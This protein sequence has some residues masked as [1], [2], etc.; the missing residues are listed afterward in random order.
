[1]LKAQ[2]LM[3]ELHSQLNCLRCSI[4]AIGLLSCAHSISQNITITDLK[5]N[6]LVGV[7]VFSEDYQFTDISNLDGRVTVNEWD[8]SS[9]L[10]FRFLGFELAQLTF[11]SL[12]AKDFL[13]TLKPGAIAIEEVVIF[14]RNRFDVRDIPIQTISFSQKEIRSTQPQSTADALANHG[15]IFVQKSQMGGGSPVIRGFEANRVLLVI[16]GIRM[17][18]AIYRNGHLQN[19][20][21]TDP[22]I[23]D[24]IDVL[25]GAN[26]L[27]FGSDAL[28]GVVHFQTMTPAF[29]SQREFSAATKA[30][31][32]YSTANK[33]KTAHFDVS[34][35]NDKWSSLTS[36]TR[37][38][39]DDLR[40]GAN[41]PERYPLFGLRPTYQGLNTEGEDIMVTNENPNVQVGTA[42]DQWDLLQKLTHKLDE[43]ATLQ[44]N[45]QYSRSSDIPRYDNLTE[46]RNGQLRFA[47]WYYGPQKRWM[48]SASFET[49]KEYKFFD[50][51]DIIASYQKLQESRVSRNFGSVIRSSQV[52]DVRVWEFAADMTKLLKGDQLRLDYGMH[53]QYNDVVSTASDRN[54]RTGEINEDVLTRYAS[55]S[56]S[57]WTSGAFIL[58]T[59]KN[60]ALHWN[61]GLR[62]SL[63]GY[64]LRYRPASIVDW[65]PSFLDGV[66][67]VNDA[68][69]WSAGLT[70]FLPYDM[71]VKAAASTAFRAPNVD[72][73]SRIRINSSE[74]SFPNLNLGP[75]RSINAE[76][77]LSKSFTE[78]FNISATGYI[79]RLTDAIAMSDFTTPEGL[80]VWITQGD[81]LNVVANQNL[82]KALIYGL[83]VNA[84]A[85]FSQVL[86]AT[87][88]INW[89][90]GRQLFDNEDAVP[91]GHIPPMYGTTELIYENDRFQGRLSVR[92]NGFKSID[93]FG[94]SVD[95]PEFATPEGSLAWTT[96]NTYFS[97]KFS[98][99]L[100]LSAAVENVFDIHYRTFSSGVSA[101]GRNVLLTLSG[102]F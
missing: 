87:S 60:Q 48:T 2:K 37:S 45:M 65:P 81:T 78:R 14:G 42:Y 101:P 38:D 54:I 84:T 17:N 49:Y 90:R 29:T 93:A 51:L 21:T 53:L 67:G 10:N 6:P 57:Y 63:S 82:E 9:E 4:L 39:F 79:T 77:T 83:S 86:S 36:V 52:E 20:I 71:I 13:V 23:M 41:R 62:Y 95:N 59:V 94:G 85:E 99:N 75:E 18:N 30:Y 89:T 100:S 3:R 50:E 34:L 97:Y 24:R 28:G 33:E 15:N 55:D 56:N 68:L 66:S 91:L 69:T 32:R 25:F 40:S 35:T 12:Q 7:E 58:I 92:Y 98:K 5:G 19:A 46:L 88:S 8:R 73:F 26:S 96:F 61:T 27:M 76:L 74:I 22:S 16:D 1:M 47:E 31:M 64:A 11:D 72:D 43:N 80:A 44:I 102:S 70:Y